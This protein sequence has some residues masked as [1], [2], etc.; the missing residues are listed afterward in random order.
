MMMAISRFL[1][2]GKA[3]Q[4]QR[5]FLQQVKSTNH[6]HKR[7][8]LNRVHNDLK[9]STQVFITKCDVNMPV[10]MMTSRP[11]KDL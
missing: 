6:F 4:R 10:S 2:C 9:Y 5:W 3:Q 11:Y 7:L 1:F 8:V